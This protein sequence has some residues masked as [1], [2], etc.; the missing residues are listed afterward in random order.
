MKSFC[1][2]LSFVLRRASG[3]STLLRVCSMVLGVEGKKIVRPLC[4]GFLCVWVQA[5]KRG[6]ALPSEVFMAGD[7]QWCSMF[8]FVHVSSHHDFS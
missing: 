4:A 7:W 1:L 6:S 3:N 5:T 8:N 2:W